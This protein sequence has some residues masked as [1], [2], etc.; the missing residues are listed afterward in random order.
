MQ[1]TGN[2]L[3]GKADEHSHNH[4]KT[5]STV[6]HPHHSS[7]IRQLALVPGPR[8]AMIGVSLHLIISPTRALA[9]SHPL[10]LLNSES[11]LLPDGD[12]VYVS[13]CQIY[14][15]SLCNSKKPLFE[16]G[17]PAGDRTSNSCLPLCV[18]SHPAGSTA[19]RLC[20]RISRA[21]PHS[22]PHAPS[23]QPPSGLRISR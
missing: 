19:H 6:T 20:L 10:A 15:F 5:P 1:W 4:E 12:G 7:T 2:V 3:S 9:Q 14:I 22:K 13:I 21:T 11:P 23:S 8:G 18:P 16:F 17:Q